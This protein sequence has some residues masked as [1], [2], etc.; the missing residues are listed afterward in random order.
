MNN[1]ISMQRGVKLRG[2]QQPNGV[3]VRDERDQTQL[4]RNQRPGSTERHQSTHRLCVC[5]RLIC[6]HTGHFTS[7]LQSV[8]WG[9]NICCT[10]LSYYVKY[11][12]VKVTLR[13][14][15]I[16]WAF[17]AE[18]MDKP[19]KKYFLTKNMSAQYVK[20]GWR[21]TLFF[22]LISLV[23]IPVACG[24]HSINFSFHWFETIEDFTKK[25][26]TQRSLLQSKNMRD[27]LL[28]SS[29]MNRKQHFY[30]FMDI[31]FKCLL[32]VV[33]V[34]LPTGWRYNRLPPNGKNIT[35]WHYYYKGF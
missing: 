33:P 12:D 11:L 25:W 4:C 7:D 1:Q 23:L 15:T 30:I 22:P 18:A 27:V 14:I 9:F 24:V 19:P 29:F 28:F 3:L 31:S 13:G 2:F 34:I 21:D 10:Q 20:N 17:K 26:T 8:E 35:E 6:D 5:S 32:S 16:A